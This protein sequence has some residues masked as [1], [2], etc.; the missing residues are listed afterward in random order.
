MTKPE[1]TAGLADTS[2]SLHLSRAPLVRVLCQVRWPKLTKFDAARVA[3]SLAQAIGD[4][5][6]FSDQQQEMQITI[7]QAGVH[8]QPG[9]VIRRFLSH[10]RAWT[11]TLSEMFLALDTTEYQGHDDF[12]A[13]LGVVMDALLV[14]APIPSLARVGYRYTNRLD[15]EADLERLK[16]LFKPSILGWLEQGDSSTVIQTVSETLL[17]QGEHYLM[18]RSALLGPGAVLD[19]TLP[20]VQTRSW[21]VDIDSFV[22]SA[23][24]PDMARGLARDLSARASGHFRTLITPEFL[25][26]FK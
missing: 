17:K 26:R 5:Y 9:G 1:R 16:T 15:N 18:V 25:E 8:Q 2:A 3:D 23:Q 22:E 10:D 14:A 7:D 24:E 11:V 19:P 21:L 12:I 20:P 6:P 13:R 4:D